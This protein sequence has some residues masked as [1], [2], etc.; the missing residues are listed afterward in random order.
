MKFKVGMSKKTAA[1]L[2][3]QL[4]ANHDL[5]SLN[6]KKYSLMNPTYIWTHMACA[7]SFFKISY[8]ENK[9]VPFVLIDLVLWNLLQAYVL[10]DIEW[11]EKMT[12]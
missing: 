6:G 10:Y 8:I 3:R 1:L 9:S 5:K 11:D 7:E 2:V 4:L 12:Q